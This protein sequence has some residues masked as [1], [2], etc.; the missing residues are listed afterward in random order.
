MESDK[1]LPSSP[2]LTLI[3]ERINTHRERFR[4]KVFERD[5]EAVLKEVRGQQNTNVT[6]L[7]INAGGSPAKETDDL[8][9]LLETIL[10]ELKPETGLVIDS[11]SAECLARALF[12][13]HDRPGTIVN[14]ITNDADKLAAVMPLIQQHRTGVVAICGSIAASPRTSEERLAAAE[15][16]HRALSSAGVPD[17]RIYFDPLL[18]P[19]A[20]DPQQTR[21]VLET[22]REL[23]RRWPAAH[24]IVGLS[25]VSFNMPDRSLLN[26]TYLAMLLAAGANAV[27]IN[28][29]DAELVAILTAARALLGQ[30]DFLTDYL[31]LT[32]K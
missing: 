13:I 24:A 25:N 2:K 28:P 27:I 1:P 12:R 29:G 20:Y 16:L 10:P 7:D 8:L 17:E 19:L 32:T 14:A 30:D 9:W 31:S 4:L 15:Q 18:L 6:H 23:R 5:T 11:M 26:R 22:V 21:A 3:G